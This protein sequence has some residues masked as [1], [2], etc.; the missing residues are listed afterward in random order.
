MSLQIV[1]FQTRI[2]LILR[3]KN[4]TLQHE[5]SHRHESVHLSV[6]LTND[7]SIHYCK[8]PV[9]VHLNVNVYLTFFEISMLS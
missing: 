2:F 8:P 6:V 9:I 1:L 4:R 7:L 3:D 5:V